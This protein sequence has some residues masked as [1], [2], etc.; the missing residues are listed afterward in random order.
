MA[1]KHGV[2]KM[3]LADQTESEQLSALAEHHGF[4]HSDLLRYALKKAFKLKWSVPLWRK[5]EEDLKP[6]SIR[7][8]RHRARKSEVD[9][10]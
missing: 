10:E 7:A 6:Q 9:L 4:S 3:T 1:R 5:A 8:R 2:A